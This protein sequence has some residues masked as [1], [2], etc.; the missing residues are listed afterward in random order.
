M[1]RL[2]CGAPLRVFPR[3]FSRLHS[4]EA[5]FLFFFFKNVRFRSGDRKSGFLLDSEKAEKILVASWASDQ[6][7]AGGRYK[8]CQGKETAAVIHQL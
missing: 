1:S 5:T 6:G 8:Q 3:F 2:L 4:H 7:L